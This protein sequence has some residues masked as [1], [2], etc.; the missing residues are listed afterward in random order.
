M[1][2][3]ILAACDKAIRRGTDR[4]AERVRLGTRLPHFNDPQDAKNHAALEASLPSVDEMI[5][6]VLGKG[7]SSSAAGTPTSAAREHGQ[8]LEVRL[9]RR[10]AP[11]QGC[12][13]DQDPRTAAQPEP[14]A[15]SQALEAAFGVCP[16][17]SA[18]WRLH[19]VYIKEAYNEAISRD[20]PLLRR[21]Y[22][23]CGW[24]R[25]QLEAKWIHGRTPMP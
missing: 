22:N 8:S 3:A 18:P 23:T 13:R 9:Q 14:C 19:W 7:K 17:C 16:E 11:P 12:A 10:P 21:R 6:A 5:D 15:R 2:P 4:A 24:T 1:D 20:L 25:D